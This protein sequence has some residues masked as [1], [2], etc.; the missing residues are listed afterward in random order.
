[1]EQHYRG[2]GTKRLKLHQ[3]EDGTYRVLRFRMPEVKKSRSIRIFLPHD[4]D[5]SSKHYPVLYVL[6]GQNIFSDCT[7]EMGAGWCLNENLD[8]LMWEG[9]TQGCIVVGIE[10]ARLGR[11]VE[12]NP[13][14]GGEAHAHFIAHALKPRIDAV[15]RTKPGREHTGIAGSSAGGVMALFIGLKYQEIFSKIGAFSAA[16]FWAPRGLHNFKKH[17]PMKIY[18]DLGT[19]EHE[20][21]DDVTKDYE[22]SIYWYHA[23]LLKIGFTMQ[24]TCIVQEKNGR[25]NE[26]DWA[27]RFPFAYLWLYEHQFAKDKLVE[28]VYVE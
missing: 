7:S 22:W 18:I 12:Y 28:C 19:I 9:R 16:I 14:E 4:Y 1:M 10:N 27:R 20:G 6:D 24:E 11:G 13:T 5:Y 26:R 21:W 2:S 15:F 17:F 23:Y 8:G 25:H 3:L